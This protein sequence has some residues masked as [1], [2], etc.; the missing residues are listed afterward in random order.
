MGVSRDE[1]FKVGFGAGLGL[2]QTWIQ[3]PAL[4]LGNEVT[5]VDLLEHLEPQLSHL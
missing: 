1:Q 3:V 5:L 2:Q 4:P